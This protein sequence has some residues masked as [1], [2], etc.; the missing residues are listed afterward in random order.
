[1]KTMFSAFAFCVACFGPAWADWNLYQ[2]GKVWEV[3]TILEVRPATGSFQ[4]LGVGP[5]GQLDWIKDVTRMAFLKPRESISQAQLLHAFR[6]LEDRMKPAQSKVPDPTVIV[7][8]QQIQPHPVDTSR[9]EPA[10]LSGP[11]LFPE[12]ERE[13][14]ILVGPATPAFVGR[15]SQKVFYPLNESTIDWVRPEDRVFFTNAGEAI[16][17]GYRR[18]N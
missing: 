1:M 11:L 3:E 7:Q 13:Q 8:F 12:A 9:Q 15:K 2:N 17:A 5:E 14:K 16:A 18:A 6:A 4:V 10:P